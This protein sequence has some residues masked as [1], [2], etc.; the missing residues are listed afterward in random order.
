M[1]KV[2]SFCFN[3]FQENTYLLID[4]SG[5]DCLVV[6]PGMYEPAEYDQFYDYLRTHNLTPRKIINTHA[7][8]DHIFGVQALKE[9]FGIPFGLHAREMPVLEGAAGSAQLFGFALS[10]VPTVDFTI[11]EDEVIAF[12]LSHIQVKFTP[13]HSPGSI[14]FYQ[15]ESK[16]VLSGDVLFQGSIGRTDLPG[17]HTETLL[18]SIRKELYTLPDHTAVYPGHGAMTNI[19]VEKMTNPFIKA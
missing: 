4:E 19:G 13:G 16:W 11:S 15:P 12:G 7:H 5:R 17:G 18:N 8:I 6:D 2:V 14:T 1:I 3:P 9:K 10:A